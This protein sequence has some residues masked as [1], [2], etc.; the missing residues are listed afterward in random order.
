MCDILPLKF[1]NISGPD[2]SYMY[3][4]FL[5]N[6]EKDYVLVVSYNHYFVNLCSAINLLWCTYAINFGP[7][8]SFLYINIQCKVYL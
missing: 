6:A 4:V 5:T 2:S 1:K 7:A 3:I 8:T